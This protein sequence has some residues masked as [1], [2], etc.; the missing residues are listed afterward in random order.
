MRQ[1]A[2]SYSENGG[3]KGRPS[4]RSSF[5]GDPGTTFLYRPRSFR[6]SPAPRSALRPKRV[7]LRAT[8][9]FAPTRVR[10]W[11]NQEWGQMKRSKG[12]KSS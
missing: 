6:N 2:A 5:L 7:A 11:I 3:A 12:A 9:G 1:Q 8:Q 10:E 4:W